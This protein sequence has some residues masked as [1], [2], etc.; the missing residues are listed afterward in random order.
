MN[1]KNDKIQI[2]CPNTELTQN[3]FSKNKLTLMLYSENDYFEPIMLYNNDKK[4]TNKKTFFFDYNTLISETLLGNTMN[5]IIN[6]LLTEC[7]SKPSIPKNLNSKIISILKILFLLLKKVM[8]LLLIDK[9][10][11]ITLKL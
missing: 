2:I 3:I 9:S 5:N 10:L 11:I 6:S 8:M 7:S 1:D 4:A